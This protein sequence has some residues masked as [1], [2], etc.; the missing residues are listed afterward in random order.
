MITSILPTY[1][2]VTREKVRTEF[3]DL[4]RSLSEA[5]VQKHVLKEVNTTLDAYT[6]QQFVRIAY[7]R[8]DEDTYRLDTHEPVP[9]LVLAACIACFLQ[10]HR[11]NDTAVSVEDLLT[12]SDGPGVV[13]QLE[14]KHP[15][16]LLEQLKMQPGFSLESRADLDQIRLSDTALDYVWMER[17][18][19][20]K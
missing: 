4:R 8:L 9:S 2:S 10:H 17:Y 11:S 7:L 1:K 6:N 16:Q 13:L 19:A 15:R 20:S 12:T 18:Y 3:A 5:S 14:E